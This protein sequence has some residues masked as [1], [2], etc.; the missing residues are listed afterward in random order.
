MA[1]PNVALSPAERLALLLDQ[2]VTLRLQ[3][4]R[5]GYVKVSLRCNLQTVSNTISHSVLQGFTWAATQRTCP[6][7]GK[8]VVLSMRANRYGLPVVL[9]FEV[10]AD[11][12]VGVV[13]GAPG[14]RAMLETWTEARRLFILRKQRAQTGM[15]GLPQPDQW[16][17]NNDPAVFSIMPSATME[18]KS[19]SLDKEQRSRK[20]FQDRLSCGLEIS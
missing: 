8:K 16:L 4:P 10:Q 3:P 2:D 6:R 18:G 12:N 14:C 1:N 19:S 20:R 7:P 17:A 9:E 5:G 13:V 11:P 15:H